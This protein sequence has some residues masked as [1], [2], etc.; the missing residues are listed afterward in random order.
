LPRRREK[1]GQGNRPFLRNKQI[2]DLVIV[3]TGP[4]KPANAPYVEHFG[5][6]T[7][8]KCEP[9]FWPTSGVLARLLRIIGDAVAEY[10]LAM[11]DEA[12]VAPF[13]AHPIA[14]GSG[15]GLAGGVQR[16]YQHS[17]PGAEDLACYILVERA[18]QPAVSSGNGGA[19]PD[20]AVQPCQLL[21]D[22]QKGE[23]IKFRPAK[24]SRQP[25]RKK[26]CVGQ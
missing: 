23:R 15:D 2:V 4:P 17:T 3:A 18:R 13:S 11:M 26:T 25:H 16:A 8:K 19:P 7:G 5:V 10:P 12:A 20:R 22:G 21:D 6:R 14:A 1:V 9:E 24:R